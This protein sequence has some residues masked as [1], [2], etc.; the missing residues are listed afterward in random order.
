[1]S[2]IG[3]LRQIIGSYG[4]H[5]GLLFTFFATINAF[6]RFQVLEILTIVPDDLDGSY[7]D[8][9]AE[10]SSDFLTSEQ[11]Y[12]HARA[13]SSLELSES[14]LREAIR[15]G[16]ACY[17]IFHDRVLASYGWY[18]NQPTEIDSELTFSFDPDF[19]YMYKGLTRPEFRG[20]RLHAIGMSRA[21]LAKVEEGSKGIISYVE[22]TNFA[23]LKSCYRMGYR[24]AG[25]IYIAKLFGRFFFWNTPGCRRFAVSV[26]PS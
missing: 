13:D 22:R 8:L 12:Q 17:A 25:S 9:P 23:S 2:K 24:R 1:M 10:Y 16:D 5:S 3:T 18:S 21:L 4:Y 7:L 14:F 19:I 15:K 11:L 20:K 6:F 26:R